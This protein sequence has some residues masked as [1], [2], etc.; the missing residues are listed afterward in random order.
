MAADAA[1]MLVSLGVYTHTYLFVRL[2]GTTT[3]THRLRD[4]RG[5]GRPAEA[6][7][8]NT[9]KKDVNVFVSICLLFKNAPVQLERFGSPG[10]PAASVS[11][12]ESS[13]GA[14]NGPVGTVDT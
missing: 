14:A 10:V 3:K 12:P 2:V 7:G 6:G 4:L 11:L 8:V 13:H 5:P 9:I 1:L